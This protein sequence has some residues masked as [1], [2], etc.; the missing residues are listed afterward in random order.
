MKRHLIILCMS[1]LFFASKVGT[2]TVLAQEDECYTGEHYNSDLFGYGNDN[3]S[4]PTDASEDLD[5]S[6]INSAPEQKINGYYTYSEAVSYVR[7]QMVARNESIKFNFS[8]SGNLKQTGKLDFFFD[9]VFSETDSP[10]E[11]DYLKQHY[12]RA[13]YNWQQKYYAAYGL[14]LY[15]I[16]INVKYLSTAAQENALTQK[17]NQVIASLDLKNDNEYQKVKK[18][19]DYITSNVSYDNSAMSALNEVSQRASGMSTSSANELYDWLLSKYPYAWSAY[20]A[21]VKEKCVCQGYANLFYRLAREAGL[22]VRYISGNSSGGD[23]AWN[24]VRIG[25]YYYN[26]DSTWDAGK[27]YYSY[28]LKN[29]SGFY[30]HTRDEEYSTSVFNTRCP[31]A[32]TS[33]SYTDYDPNSYVTSV[34]IVE[35]EN[36]KMRLGEIRALNTKVLPAN[37]SNKELTWTSSDTNVATVDSKGVVTVKNLGTTLI[38]ARS[39]NNTTVYD[40]CL[41]TVSDTGWVYR[42]GTWSYIVSGEKVTGWK[43]LGNYWYYFNSNGTMQTGWVK[44]KDKWYYFNKSGQMQTG[45]IKLPLG[46]YYLQPGGPVSIGWNRIDGYWYYMDCS[47]LMLTGWQ[48]IDGDWFYF[49]EG[50]QMHQGWLALKGKWYFFYGNGK[51]ATGW[52]QRGE[53]WYYFDD[54]GVMVVGEYTIDT[55]I[56]HFSSSGAWI[57]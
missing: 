13:D 57:K 20:G 2:I 9:E 29:M 44:V 43:K 48:K 38:L 28:F 22:S 49:K 4:T 3:E 47:G 19:Y 32:S 45:W 46:W 21:A 40:T 35:G 26:V 41:I 25:K 30:D 14:Y 39:K 37:I 12:F 55:K 11:G 8:W 33:F 16:E 51:M 15:S 10:V 52:V 31:M 56:Y 36:H 42:N 24:I 17:V 54:N 50:G 5:I 27:S 53:D 34:T 7:K 1:I 18:I 6:F 23:H